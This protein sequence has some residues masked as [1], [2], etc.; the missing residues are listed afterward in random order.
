MAIQIRGIAIFL[1]ATFPEAMPIWGWATAMILIM[2]IYSEVGGLKAIIY[3]DMLQGIILLIVI[4][5]IA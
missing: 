3:S 1:S 4:C 5:V 2:L